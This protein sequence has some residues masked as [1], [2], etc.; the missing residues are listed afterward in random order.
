MG[1]H[2]YRKRP[3]HQ[4]VSIVHPTGPFGELLASEATPVVQI[5]A[6]YGLIE[7]H[8]TFSASGGSATASDSMF[9]VASSPTIGS[10]GVIRSRK[11]VRYRSG[12]GTLLRF[13]AAYSSPVALS[14]QM[15]G[16]FN[17]EGGFWI[18]YNGTRFGCMRQS[19]GRLE[20]QR[21]TLSAGASGTESVTVTLAGTDFTFN[22]TAG[23]AAINAF[24]I[25]GQSYT[26]W[27]AYQNGATV[28]FVSTTV[29]DK[30]GAFTYANNSAGT[31]AG[32]FAE[33]QAGVAHTESWH[34]LDT[35]HDKDNADRLNVDP[36]DGTGPSRITLDPTKLNVYEIAFQWLGAGAIEFRLEESTTGYLVPFHRIDYANANTAPTLLNPTLK[37]GWVCYSLG[38]TTPLEVTGAS[39]AGFKVGPV[40]PQRNPRALVNTKTGVGT[41]FTSVLAIRVRPEFAGRVF[42]G[43]VLIQSIGVAVEGTKTA[44]AQVVLN[45]TL[46]G[47]PNW[48]YAEQANS[49]V[50]YDTSATTVTGGQIVD[51]V[52]LAKTANAQVIAPVKL[53]REDVLVVAVRASSG[54]TDATASIR[55]EED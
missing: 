31:S 40:E 38:A 17:A 33:L 5:D 48:T 7:D 12:Q 3:A 1:G 39:A 19:G 18:G 10:Y 43:E 41:S 54:T 21:L 24:E 55:W 25:A 49:R 46:G 34:Y 22:V 20:I 27:N 37:V 47:T 23:T 51:A 14:Q 28:T 8:E 53:E 16:G 4:E 36:L 6:V 11:V 42:L 52:A 35:Y 26:G 32:T 30:T 13:T 45:P 29:G 50:E 44:E 9:R 15:A 2:D